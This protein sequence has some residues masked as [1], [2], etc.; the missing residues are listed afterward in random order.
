MQLLAPGSHGDEEGQQLVGGH[1]SRFTCRDSQRLSS[2]V[3]GV[4][5]HLT[6]CPCW[7][8]R[9]PP[10]PVVDASVLNVHWGR[11]HLSRRSLLLLRPPCS[12]CRN[13]R[14]HVSGNLTIV[15]NAL[16]C[17]RP[18]LAGCPAPAFFACSSK[19]CRQQPISY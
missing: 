2:G 11:A 7:S 6:I 13:F 3:K 17:G 10:A 15:A 9:S 12:P 4:A 16:P 8:S 18:R 14:N 5:N 19:C 1:T